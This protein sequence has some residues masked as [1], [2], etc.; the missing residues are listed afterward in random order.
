METSPA[1]HVPV[2][3]LS[4]KGVLTKPPRKIQVDFSPPQPSDWQCGDC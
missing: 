4:E 2:L 3:G 1:P